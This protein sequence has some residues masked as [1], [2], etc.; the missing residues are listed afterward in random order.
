[1]T[2]QLLHQLLE[3]ASRD[4]PDRIAV[5]DPGVASVTFAELDRL[6]ERVC[7]TLRAKSVRPG[8]RVGIHLGKTIGTVAC[9]FGVLKCGAAYVPVDST[10]PAARNGYIFT[11]CAVRQVITRNPAGTGLDVSGA[12]HDPFGASDAPLEDLLLL[13]GATH[14]PRGQVQVPERLA[15][16][17]YTSGSTG[18]PKGVVL[19]HG[20]ALAFVDWCSEAFLPVHTDHFSAHAPFHFDLSIFDIFVSLKHGARLVLIGEQIGRQPKELASLISRERI[21]IWYSTPSILRLLLE[22]KDIANHDYSAIRLVLFAGEVFPIKHLRALQA[23]WP[24]PRY[25]NLYGPTETNVCTYYEVPAPLPADR[26]EPVPIGR[27][28]SGDRGMLVGE[29]KHEVPRG[30]E[31][32]LY[33]AGPSVTSGYWNLPERNASA[34][35]AGADGTRWYRTGD[36]V[37]EDGDG[38][39]LYVGRHDRMIK[40]RGYRVE[41]GEIE[42]ALYRHDSITEAAVVALPDRDGGLMLKAFINWIGQDRP[43][44]IALKRYCMENLP[45]YMVPDRF[46]LRPSLPKTST[47][48]IDYQRLMEME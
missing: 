8:D 25:F 30:A 36:I 18:R 41:L 1:V 23:L 13:P 12:E 24:Q 5:V 27:V 3:Q 42:A 34:F 46:S 10:A 6:A 16:I 21:S 38:N 28:C 15:Y 19:T 37:R 2:A 39:Y 35:H 7:R 33:V 20:N 48:K 26:T 44:I 32:E 14:Y 4:H 47:D 11:D 17:L 9:I 43:S 40:R 45:A 31:G 29:H 22:T